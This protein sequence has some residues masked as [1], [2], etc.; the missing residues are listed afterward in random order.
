MNRE[1]KF[2]AWTDNLKDGGEMYYQETFVGYQPVFSDA[3]YGLLNPTLKVMQFTGVLDKNG[4]EIYEGDILRTVSC[5][6]GKK[7]C[8]LF[9]EEILEV[10]FLN[11][12][13]SPFTDQN[14]SENHYSSCNKIVIGNIYENPELLVNK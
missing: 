14:S 7:C 3:G 5:S 6:C 9:R 12:G 11:S 10:K 1:I 13:F 8:E 2:R 4:K